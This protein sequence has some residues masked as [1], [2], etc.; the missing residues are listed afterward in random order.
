VSTGA[1]VTTIAIMV[2]ASMGS[3]TEKALVSRAKTIELGSGSRSG[4]G[5]RAWANTAGDGVD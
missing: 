4:S 2:L 5:K 3:R 1:V